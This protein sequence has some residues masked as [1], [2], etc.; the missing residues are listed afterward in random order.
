M[1]D[2]I[3]QGS[4]ARLSLAASGT[5]LLALAGS[6]V[7]DVLWLALLPAAAL[8]FLAVGAIH[9]AQEGRDGRVGALGA[10]M[11][12]TGCVAL[13]ATAIAGLVVVA[14]RGVEPE[15]LSVAALASGA[16]LVAGV[17]AFG[18]ALVAT[19]TAPRAAAVLF[20]TAIPL[21]V[22]IDFL[23]NLAVP[24]PLFFTGAGVYI[25]LGLLALSIIR[26]GRAAP[27]SRGIGDDVPNPVAVAA[28][29]L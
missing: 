24:F 23:P 25:G 8:L 28:P 26:L 16:I 29:A 1:I 19:R 22:A 3:G 2:R 7:V 9:A 20:A 4:P 11:V 13:V 5:I 21:G 6:L 14:V 17:F 12:R 18:M 27:W 10:A 15:W